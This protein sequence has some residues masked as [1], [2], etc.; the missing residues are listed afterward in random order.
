M[1][2]GVE[3]M[4]R[5]SIENGAFLWFKILEYRCVNETAAAA[6]METVETLRVGVG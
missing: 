4:K 5:N 3:I 2:R 1:E 6:A